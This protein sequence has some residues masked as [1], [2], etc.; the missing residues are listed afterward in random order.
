MTERLKAQPGFQPFLCHITSGRPLSVVADNHLIMRWMS[1]CL[2]VISVPDICSFRWLSA[3][4]LPRYSL[5]KIAG[6]VPYS[7]VPR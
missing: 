5:K 7:T 1:I 3:P 6:T 4:Y 2:V